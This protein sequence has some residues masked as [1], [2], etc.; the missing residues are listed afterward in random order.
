[1]QGGFWRPLPASGL[2]W[3]NTAA[4]VAAGAALQWAKVSAGRD[5]IDGVRICLFAAGVFSLAFLVGQAVLW[6]Q[7]AAAGHGLTSPA[8]AFFYLLTGL[9]GLHL[10]GGLLALGRTGIG[11]WRQPDPVRLRLRVGLC[12]AYWHFLLLV[13][14]VVAATLSGWAGLVVETCRQW[15]A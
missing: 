11:A 6:R 4:L 10:A 12:A 3:L 8:A 15:L 2:L 14:L 7:M 1:M 9:H 13:W 5:E